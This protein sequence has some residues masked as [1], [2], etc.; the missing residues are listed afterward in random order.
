MVRGFFFTICRS[1][2]E[3]ETNT[4]FIREQKSDVSRAQTKT[5]FAAIKLFETK[6]EN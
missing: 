6:K 4:R 3:S 1:F 5:N 2:R